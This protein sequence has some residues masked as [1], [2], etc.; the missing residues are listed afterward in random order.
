MSHGEP[1][2][3]TQS[4]E[5][6]KIDLSSYRTGHLVERLTDLISVPS[7]LRKIVVTMFVFAVIVVAFVYWAVGLSTMSLAPYSLVLGY[8]ISASL[9]L[10][11]LF[12][13][14]R[15]IAIA[16]RHVEEILNIIL[17]ITGQAAGDYERLQSG[18]ARMPSAGELI[19]QVYEEVV[20]PAMEKAVVG[21]FGFIGRPVV[22]MYR[23]SLGAAV[24]TMLSQVAKIKLTSETERKLEDS[25][26]AGLATTAKY[27][28]KIKAFTKAASSVVSRISSRI[29][30]VAMTPMYLVFL[31]FM[32]IGSVPILVMKFLFGGEGEI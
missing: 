22:W 9:V 29:R 28:Q 8:S 30:F 27:S 3:P 32:A 12:G 18:E 7:T 20:L 11:V 14:V 31:V 15:V 5:V 26:E 13:I 2:A 25:T 19:Q 23:R 6:A 21:A 24:R 4:G 10:G 1:E 17:D 16:M